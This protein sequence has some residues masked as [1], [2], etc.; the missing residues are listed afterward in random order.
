MG[1]DLGVKQLFVTPLKVFKN[2]NTEFLVKYI[3]DLSL[4]ATISIFSK[5]RHLAKQNGVR[6]KLPEYSSPTLPCAVLGNYSPVID[7]DGKVS[8][9]SGR[10]NAKIGKI[11]NPDIASIWGKLRKK[12]ESKNKLSKFCSSCLT[13][14][15]Q[16][17]IILEMPTL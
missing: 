12:T 2:H 3:P 1:I 10:E 5:I 15:N 16:N 7:I 14:K 8:F 11:T 17:K 6:L 13:F 9:C 4:P